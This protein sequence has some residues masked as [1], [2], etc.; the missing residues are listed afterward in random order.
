[1]EPP[2][3]NENVSTAITMSDEMYNDFIEYPP[4][5]VWHGQDGWVNRDG[6][7]ISFGKEGDAGG[8]AVEKVSVPNRPNLALRKKPRERNW[9]QSF[10][11]GSCIMVRSSE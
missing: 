10:R 1:M 6:L 2:T 8:I 3:P 5:T 9:A 7:T 4:H 11:S